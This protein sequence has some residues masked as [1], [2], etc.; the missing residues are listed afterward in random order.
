MFSSAGTGC[1]DHSTKT[2]GIQRWVG[3]GVIA[4]NLVSTATYFEGAGRR[5]EIRA[6]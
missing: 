2:E 1:G 4:D 5:I 6:K 3:L